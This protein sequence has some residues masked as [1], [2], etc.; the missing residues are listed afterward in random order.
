MA[1]T[2][3]EPAQQSEQ[4]PR[5]E[6]AQKPEREPEQITLMKRVVALAEKQTELAV[7]RTR[8]AAEQS[9]MSAER[10]DMSADRS[11]MSAD[12][13]RMSEDRSRM[14]ADRSEMSEARTYLN[15]ERTLSVW[16]R[17]S[18]ALMVLGMAVDRFGL[19]LH[20]VPGG[21]ADT[22]VRLGQL[23]A[24]SNGAGMALVAFGV[25]MALSTGLRYLAYARAWRKAHPHRAPAY[26]GPFLG[27]SFA[28]LVGAFGVFLLVLMAV[29][30]T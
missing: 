6:R 11:R 5:Q 18:L 24:L 25:V 16:V 23:G 15:A 9:R 8:M 30:P 21:E 1:E 10:S 28:V 2:D 4:Q 17:T 29:F 22:G 3:N 27:T 26:H 20:Q 7:E 19:L 14:S 13:S 12:R